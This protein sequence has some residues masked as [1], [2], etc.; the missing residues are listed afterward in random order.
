MHPERLGHPGN[1]P[2]PAA[3]VQSRDLHRAGD[4]SE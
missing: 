3:A 4:R 1:D 2:S